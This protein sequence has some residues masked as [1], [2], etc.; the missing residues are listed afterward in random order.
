MERFFTTI[1]SYSLQ[2]FAFQVLAFIILERKS[3]AL[4]TNQIPR[5]LESSK[6]TPEYLG[7]DTQLI[8]FFGV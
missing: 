5:I 7:G 2:V 4:V 8:F 1:L 6:C 3:Q